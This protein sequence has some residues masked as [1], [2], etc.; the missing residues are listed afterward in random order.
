MSDISVECSAS[1]GGWLAHVAVTDRGSTRRYQVRVSA[2]ELAR[3]APGASEPDD[4]VLRSFEF[5]LDR[6][7]KES[8]LA[9]FDLSVIGRYFP[10]YERTIKPG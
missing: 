2:A 8:I 4:L 7:P 10:E 9:T 1:G 5:L 3:F 6:E